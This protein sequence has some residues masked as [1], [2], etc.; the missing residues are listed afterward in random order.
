VRKH[1]IELNMS[2]PPP[3]TSHI[4]DF[5]SIGGLSDEQF[6]RLC[7]SNSDLRFERTSKGE[8]I[9]MSPTDGLTGSRSVEIGSELYNW[10]KRSNIGIVFDSSTG[11]TLPNGA[12][13]SPDAA[14]IARERWNSL[15]RED[16]KHFVPLCPDFVVEL[17]SE[18]DALPIAQAKMDEWMANGCR[19]AWL[20][21]AEGEKA[22]I[23]RTGA[24]V[25]IV[26][27]EATLSGGDVLPGFAFRLRS[28]FEI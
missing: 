17:L 22:Y 26:S 20:I 7:V 1:V 27:F 5:S 9:L 24:E 14:W 3:Y 11:F 15:S 10:N 4:I 16:Q 13:R 23:Y 2:I 6:Y 28:L 25:E 18:S 8:I 12:T 21:D 19:L